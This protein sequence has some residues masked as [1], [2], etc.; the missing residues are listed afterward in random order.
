M[1]KEELKNRIILILSVLTLIL[2]VTTINSCSESYKQ[3]KQKEKELR[4]RIE[5]EEKLNRLSDERNIWLSNLDKCQQELRQMN[6]KLQ[7]TE[8]NLFQQELINKSLKEELD[9]ITKL[10]ETLEESLKE[11]LVSKPDKK[12]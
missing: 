6:E 2:F 11:A 8:K 3:R 12:R 4:Q 9:K 1:D 5:L 7:V 10:K